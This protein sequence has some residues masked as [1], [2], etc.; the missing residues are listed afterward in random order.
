M[1]REYARVRLRIWADTDFRSLSMPAQHLY[2]ALM[3]SPTLNLCGEADWRPRR[4]A[5][6]TS[7][8][9]VADVENA[10]KELENQ[11]YIV[12]D[13]DMEEVLLRSFVRHDGLI[14]TPN[15]ASAMAKDYA[16]VASLKLRGC[17]IHELKRLHNEEPDMKGWQAIPELFEEP[18]LN[19]SELMAS[20]NPSPM[21]SPNPSGDGS[22]IPS[23]K[24]TPTTN[25]P[26]PPL[27]AAQAPPSTSKKRPTKLDDS[28]KPTESH[29]QTARE[30]GID[31]EREAATFRAYAEAHDRRLVN[32]NA[33][34]TQWLLKARPGTSHKSSEPEVPHYWRKQGGGAA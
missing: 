33:G 31:L 1:A 6:M 13:E 25:S 15:I 12:V 20:P 10:A 24:P 18:S 11:L 8:A 19:P 26:Q 34:F 21:A 23:P 22:H 28:W 32:W 27:E 2:F 3:T 5:A 30:N 7:G 17:V 14:K 16:A 4:M 29:E 9:T